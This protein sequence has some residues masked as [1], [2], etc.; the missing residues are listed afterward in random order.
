MNLR[1]ELLKEHSVTQAI[2]ISEWA[3]QDKKHMKELMTIFFSKEPRIAQ[4]A[5]WAASKAYE[6]KPKWFSVYIPTLIHVLSEETHG[7]VR[8][9]SLRMLQSMDVPEE[10]H[11]ELV[12]TTFRI[13]SDPKEDI[14]VK[15]FAMTVA[16]NHLH[17]YP[18][19][20]QEFKLIIEDQLPYASAAIKSR[21][22]KI[23][24]K[25]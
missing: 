6:I 8:R 22:A 23:L 1:N 5:A 4:R 3:L 18:E 20:K 13:L 9:N 10:Y 16:F 19:L 7:G 14:A 11:G 17:Y 2:R 25:L 12:D 21:A 24:V 15:A